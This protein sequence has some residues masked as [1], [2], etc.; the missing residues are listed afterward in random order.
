MRK[1]A[2]K[3]S[4]KTEEPTVVDDDL[5]PG[6]PDT[7]ENVAK[8]LVKTPPKKPHEWKFMQKRDDGKQVAENPGE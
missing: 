1:P 5:I 3:S 2:P 4:G 8:A 6:I 7:L